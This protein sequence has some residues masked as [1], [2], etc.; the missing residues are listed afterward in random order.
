MPG[1]ISIA[2]FAQQ[3]VQ[4]ELA[5]F[6]ERDENS[7]SSGARLAGSSCE[8]PNPGTISRSARGDATDPS[9]TV[10]LKQATGFTKM[11]S[12]RGAKATRPLLEVSNSMTSADRAASYLKGGCFAITSRV[13]VVD[14]LCERVPMSKVSSVG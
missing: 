3:V 1:L 13:L 8:Q 12:G 9:Q 11:D 14:M 6:D 7:T 5:E 4:E 2:R 10:L